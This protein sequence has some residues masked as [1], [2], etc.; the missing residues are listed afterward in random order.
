MMN[1]G[2]ID[3]SSSHFVQI[4]PYGHICH[5]SYIPF[6]R[7]KGFDKIGLQQ[8]GRSVA[9]CV[10]CL[11]SQC[12]PLYGIKMYYAGDSTSMA[13]TLVFHNCAVGRALLED[14]Q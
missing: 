9:P 4:A 2:E 13:D 6:T 11:C 8:F 1:R 12:Q 7:F 5:S 10:Y 3:S 14:I